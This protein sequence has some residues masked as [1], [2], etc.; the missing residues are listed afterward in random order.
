MLPKTRDVQIDFLNLIL[1]G[2]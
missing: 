2:D 1:A